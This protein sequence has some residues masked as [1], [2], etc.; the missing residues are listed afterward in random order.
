MLNGVNANLES[1]RA[2]ED[3]HTGQPGR[4]GGTHK[5]QG[6]VRVGRLSLAQQGVM[7]TWPRILLL[8]E[9]VR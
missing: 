7:G 3:V 9:R 5:R 4:D 1:K 8:E 2:T 6:V